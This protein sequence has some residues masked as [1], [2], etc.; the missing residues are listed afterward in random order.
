MIKSQFGEGLDERIHR[1]FPFLFVRPI[2]PNLLSVLG[3]LVSFGGAWA[4]SEGQFRLGA[5]IVLLGGCFDLVDGVVA[6][7]NHSSSRFGAFL[8][9][10][11]D[12]V[13]DG[14]LLLA[15][16]M[17]YARQDAFGL[18]WIA[19]VA[20]VAT[21]LVSY[22]KARAE[23]VVPDFK[24]GILERAERVVILVAGA[25]FG[26]MPIAVGV[27]AAG[28]T[29]TAGQRIL[30]ARRRMAELPVEQGAESELPTAENA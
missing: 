26:L 6:R 28:S 22:T 29:W 11:L 27:V 9:S 17:Y 12:R 8:D 20:L 21:Q 4:W 2:D 10:T 5:F 1:I 23:S 19:G 7:H 3:V 18:A 14:A 13:V 25:L 15:L 16:L 30:I 24:G